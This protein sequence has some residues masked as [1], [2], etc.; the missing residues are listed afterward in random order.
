MS[1]KY[2]MPDVSREMANEID[3]QVHNSCTSGCLL[4]YMANRYGAH[5]YGSA[6]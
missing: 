4:I 5:V 2:F 3:L 6:Y 1:R